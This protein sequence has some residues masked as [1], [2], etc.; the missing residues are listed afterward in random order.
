LDWIK[1]GK[2]QAEV[3]AVPLKDVERA[4]NRTDLHGKRIVLV[5]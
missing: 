1:A 5:P 3:E 4:W 2:L